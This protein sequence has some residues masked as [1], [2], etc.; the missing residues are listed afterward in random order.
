MRA[1]NY[2]RSNCLTLNRHVVIEKSIADYS[3]QNSLA[4][5]FSF[6]LSLPVTI[7]RVYVSDNEHIFESESKTPGVGRLFLLS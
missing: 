1:I 5:P 3:L 2:L 6:G 7:K 4:W